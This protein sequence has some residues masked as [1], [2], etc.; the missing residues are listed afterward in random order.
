MHNFSN[1]TRAEINAIREL[2]GV[3]PLKQPGAA[4]GRSAAPSGKATAA[5]SGGAERPPTRFIVF[6]LDM[7]DESVSY[8]I[9]RTRNEQAAERLAVEN[10]KRDHD[11]EY[12]T[13]ESAGFR[14]LGAF[15]VADL[16]DFLRESPES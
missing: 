15:D 10:R 7:A 9:V 6:V 13:D 1:L 3:E 14:A 16:L 2:D 4:T 11:L 8:Q 12:E 5:V